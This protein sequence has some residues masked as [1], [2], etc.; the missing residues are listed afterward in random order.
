MEKKL[1]EAQ[2]KQKI[3]KSNALVWAAGIVEEAG[4]MISA[5]NHKKLKDAIQSSTVGNG[6][7]QSAYC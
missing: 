6:N 4:R 7:H 2:L 3:R 1:T 5:A